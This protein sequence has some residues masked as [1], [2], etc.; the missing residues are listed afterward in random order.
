MLCGLEII[1]CNITMRIG[2]EERIFHCTR[3]RCHVRMNLTEFSCGLAAMLTSLRVECSK[4]KAAYFFR[5]S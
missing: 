2:C 4:V 1:I 5:V 3:K